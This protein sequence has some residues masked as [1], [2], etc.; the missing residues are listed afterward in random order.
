VVFA[1]LKIVSL[2]FGKVKSFVIFWAGDRWP[3]FVTA[4]P[5]TLCP[6]NKNR[7]NASFPYDRFSLRG[8]Y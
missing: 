4:D 6:P 3:E 7:K 2:L 1:F 8:I 5:Q